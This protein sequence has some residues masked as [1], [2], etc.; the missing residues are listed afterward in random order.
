[1]H[2]IQYSKPNHIHTCCK[3]KQASDKYSAHYFRLTSVLCLVCVLLLCLFLT[4]S[5]C[6]W[7]TGS[8]WC[9]SEKA[10]FSYR[11][12]RSSKQL[13]CLL[14]HHYSYLKT[15]MCLHRSRTMQYLRETSLVHKWGNFPLPGVHDFSIIAPI[16]MVLT[17]KWYCLQFWKAITHVSGCLEAVGFQKAAGHPYVS[18]SCFE[19]LWR[20]LSVCHKS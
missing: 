20:K 14:L 18:L 5:C 7:Y 11:N 15:A 13:N 3:M 17:N 1:M 19:L 6:D 4:F 2:G 9:L 12:N 16:C 8:N 10:S